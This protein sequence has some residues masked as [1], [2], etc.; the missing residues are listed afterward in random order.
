MSDTVPWSEN[1]ELFKKELMEGHDWQSFPA[2]FFQLHK[3]KVEIP[4]LSIREHISEADKWKDS[5]DLIVEGI[6]L[7]NKSRNEEFTCSADFPYHTIIVDTVKGYDIK[8]IKP[9]G[10]IMV[11]KPTGCLLWLPSL[12]S[13]KW[14]KETKFDNTRK[15][16]DEFYVC[17]TKYLQ[18]I[19]T[20]LN[21]LKRAKK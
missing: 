9:F 1:D 6:P 10:Y 21:K 16:N 13:N 14:T 20:L 8:T 19:N 15:I 5:F 7:E 11:S 2:L 3:L 4:A 18:H 17:E 12:Y